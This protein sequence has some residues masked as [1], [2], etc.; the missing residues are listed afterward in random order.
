[1]QGKHHSL[2]VLLAEK[3]SLGWVHQTLLSI[4]DYTIFKIELAVS[5][6]LISKITGYEW[7]WQW[8][9]VLPNEN[10]T[11]SYFVFSFL[12]LFSGEVSYGPTRKYEVNIGLHFQ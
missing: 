6:Y 5:D 12:L 10:C 11:I 9:V 3:I 2:S 1:M 7:Q 8:E 4:N